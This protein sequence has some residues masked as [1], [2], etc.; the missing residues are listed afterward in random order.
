[1]SDSSCT[2]KKVH[3]LEEIGSFMRWIK[4]IRALVHFTGQK[5]DVLRRLRRTGRLWDR[6]SGRLDTH[7][8]GLR[9][10]QAG[11]Q[12]D[13]QT[14]IQAGTHTD[15]QTNIHVHVQT[16][17]HTHRQIDCENDNGLLLGGYS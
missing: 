16:Y 9:R 3:G 1:M 12:A 11:R 15:R 8:D 5:V 13:I 4:V 14:Y 2:G 17:T 10:R 6:K 7:A